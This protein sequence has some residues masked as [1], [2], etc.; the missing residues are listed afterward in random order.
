MKLWTWRKAKIEN[1][2][3]YYILILCPPMPACKVWMFV[4][5]FVRK[6]SIKNLVEEIGRILGMHDRQ[7]QVEITY[8]QETFRRWYTMGEDDLHTIN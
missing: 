3:H 8:K 6:G 2:L 5:V 4:W 1:E 7:L